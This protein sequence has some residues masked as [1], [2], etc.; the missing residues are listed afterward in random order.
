MDTLHVILTAARRV[1]PRPLLLVVSLFAA[2][3]VAAGCGNSGSSAG[4]SGGGD[5]GGKS[6]IVIGEAIGRSGWLTAYDVPPSDGAKIAMA[7]INAAGGIGGRKLKMVSA[8]HQS[9]ANQGVQA[10]QKVIDD[11]AQILIGSCNYENVAPTARLANTN[12]MVVFSYCAGEPIFSRQTPDGSNSYTFDMGNETNGVGA[13]MAQFAHDKGWRKAYLFKDTS[14]NYTQAMCDFFSA[15][16][17]KFSDTQIVG[18]ET[19]KNDDPSIAGQVAK[20]KSA[21]QKPDLVVLCST[22]PGGAK[23]LRQIRSSGLDQPVL[24]G[25]GMDS[26]STAKAVPGLTDFYETVSAS[27]YGDD[28]D[29]KVNA[30]FKMYEQRTGKK[31]DGSYAIFGYS[32]I[33]A[34]KVA[35]EKAGGTDGTKLKAA[36]ETFKGQPLL[37]G[38]MTFTKDQHVDP[39]RPEKVIVF[40]NGKPKYLTTVKPTDAPSPF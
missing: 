38:P 5:A 17:K 30:F 15:A 34:L 36:L 20:A 32:I 21:S 3:A 33:Q 13:S 12:K 25:D 10:T 31:P 4:S 40:K 6:D 37:V 22:L 23:A 27:V 26:P 14:S 2:A 18:T 24:T 39:F 11:G 35:I 28:P 8:D 19:F 1:S 29:P 7:E 16:W 9:D